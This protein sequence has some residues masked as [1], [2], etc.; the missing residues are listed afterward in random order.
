[1]ERDMKSYT[2][3]AISQWQKEVFGE[4]AKISL[5]SL[6]RGFVWKPQQIEAL[7]DSI[8]SGYPIG[9]IM[10]SVDKDENRFLL[11]G[12]QRCTT[13]A[14]GHFNPFDDNSKDFLSLK[15]YKPSIWI[16]LNTINATEN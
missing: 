2:L 11:D 16:D 4:T 15:T 12:Q 9:A 10:M 3:E 7:W 14:L 5:P 13:V 6:Q 1:M 8:F